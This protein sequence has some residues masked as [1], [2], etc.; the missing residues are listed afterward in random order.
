MNELLVKGTKDICRISSL[1][2]HSPAGAFIGFKF[3]VVSLSAASF[4]PPFWEKR[5]E[6]KIFL[7][8]NAI[9]YSTL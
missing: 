1:M 5:A 2:L 7:C 9:A 4:G 6:S 3:G 8:W